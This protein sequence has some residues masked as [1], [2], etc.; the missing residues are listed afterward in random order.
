MSDP[1]KTKFSTNILAIAGLITAIG[2]MVTILHQ[3]TDIFSRDKEKSEE[4]IQFVDMPKANQKNADVID[5]KT[6]YNPADYSAKNTSNVV[7]QTTTPVTQ[8]HYKSQPAINLSGYWVDTI[9]EGRYLFTQTTS[10][11][12]NF[13]EYSF[14]E[15][16]WIITAEGVGTL[17]GNNIQ[18]S[19]NTIFGMPGTFKGTLSGQTQIT[20]KAKDM[21][22]GFE[23]ALNLIK[24]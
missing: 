13:Q 20:G 16:I 1:S 14:L 5:A 4:K 3:T 15:G 18:I 10:T 17:T 9:N 8:N 6:V 19:Y 22:T 7:E 2:G 12:F 24:E 21:A 11:G 23:V